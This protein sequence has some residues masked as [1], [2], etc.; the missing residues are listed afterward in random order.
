[1]SR[2][3]IVL[4]SRSQVDVALVL[5]PELGTDRV[6][7]EG[8]LVL[9]KAEAG[10]DGGDGKEG[11]GVEAVEDRGGKV[12]GSLQ[13]PVGSHELRE[14][15]ADDGEHGQTGVADL[16]LHHCVQVEGLGEAEGVETIVT[17]VGAI[18]LGGALE[19]GHG[20]GHLHVVVSATAS[21][22]T[23]FSS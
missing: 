2:L 21:A 12:V 11:G 19:H 9:G 16:G 20:D 10:K 18:Q 4:L 14:G 6:E 17:G 5:L 22:R 3:L 13:H 23:S 7:T 1:M 8:G 15:P